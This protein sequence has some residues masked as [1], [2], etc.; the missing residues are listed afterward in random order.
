MSA[1]ISILRRINKTQKPRR[2]NS[3]TFLDYTNAASFVDSIRKQN[4]WSAAPK[5]T[6]CL[7]GWI[8]RY[9]E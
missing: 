1:T 2:Y 7:N 9:E 4:K 8:V 6:D 3:K 5:T